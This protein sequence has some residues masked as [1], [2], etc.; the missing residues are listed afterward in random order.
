MAAL[1]PR[2]EMMIFA[3]GPVSNLVSSLLALLMYWMVDVPVLSRWL[4]VI[5]AMS[6][7]LGIFNLLPI[8]PLDGGRLFHST[9]ALCRL[10]PRTSNWLTLG[11]SF[12]IGVPL[13]CIA[14][15]LGYYWTF[16]ILLV[17]MTAAVALLAIY[18]D[19]TETEVSMPPENIAVQTVDYSNS[20]PVIPIH[21]GGKVETTIRTGRSKGATNTGDGIH[22]AVSRCDYE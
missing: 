10:H 6:L 1:T 16:F 4:A 12:L 19:E 17:L 9:L 3:A 7:T 21:E 8:W 13:A 18:G 14:W 2:Q 11:F 22:L 5:A 15:Q 20:L